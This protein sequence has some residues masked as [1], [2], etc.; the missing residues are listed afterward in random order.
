M[1]NLYGMAAKV[2]YAL[3]VIEAVALAAGGF[4]LKR[5]R[6]EIR[7]SFP[8]I[9]FVGPGPFDAALISRYSA[10]RDVLRRAEDG[11]PGDAMVGDRVDR[12][13]DFSTLGGRA[14]LEAPRDSRYQ[15]VVK[16]LRL[17]PDRGQ[18]RFLAF[19]P[20]AFME[21]TGPAAGALTVLQ[22]VRCRVAPGQTLDT[23]ELDPPTGP[24]RGRVLRA[25]P[26]GSFEWSPVPGVS[27]L[28]VSGPRESWVI[29]SLAWN[30][31]PG[32][33]ICRLAVLPLNGPPRQAREARIEGRGEPAGGLIRLGQGLENGVDSV[34]TMDLAETL[35][36]NRELAPG[37][38]SRIEAWL[39]TQYREGKPAR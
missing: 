29:V 30:P 38:I 1:Q 5:H 31:R 23:L 32:G 17:T 34:G 8:A 37:E 7:P 33:G 35:V 19:G 28:R 6:P 9:A 26:D 4:A 16:E 22:V 25:H 11:K 13:A 14:A 20:G 39:S 10:G 27:L 36:F 24:G 18:L 3:L 12:W 21:G 2:G 15:P